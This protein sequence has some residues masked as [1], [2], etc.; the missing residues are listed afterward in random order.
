MNHERAEL[1]LQ[2]Y[3]DGELDLLN[4]LELEQHLQNCEVCSGEYQD[5]LAL[6]SALQ[7]PALYRR[8][9]AKLEKSI[10]ASLRAS[11]QVTPAPRRFSWLWAGLGAAVVVAAVAMVIWFGLRPML[12]PDNSLAEEVLSSHVRSMMGNHL[13]DVASSNQHTVKPWFDGKLDFSP[14]VQDLASQ[15]FP[16]VGG[17]LDYL[18]NRPVA[19]LVYKRQLHIIN[20]FIWPSTGPGVAPETLTR[21]GYN[22]IEWT[23]SGMTYWAV[24]DLEISEL[25]QFVQLIQ[26]PPTGE[27]TVRP[28]ATNVAPATNIAPPTP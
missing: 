16:L 2:G 21:Q 14:N 4:T 22:M 15:G 18:D 13:T 27:P 1:L 28:S 10:R 23:Q 6:R 12:V 9:P 17:R 24:S 8:A 20:L 5:S 3:V 11:R 25:R 7:A 19:A 26:H